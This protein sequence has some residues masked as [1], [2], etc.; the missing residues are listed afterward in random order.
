M[1][2]TIPGAE[3][4]FSGAEKK[5]KSKDELWLWI[6]MT[7]QSIEHLKSFLNEFRSSPQILEIQ[8]SIEL[9]FI[10]PNAKELNRI[11]SESFLAASHQISEEGQY[12]MAVIR[13]PAGKINSRKAMISPYL[14]HSI[15]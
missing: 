10:G 3:D 9:E 15:S 8:K 4:L 2:S 11:F 7:D 5:L 12:S 1:V 6:P 14:P 13:F